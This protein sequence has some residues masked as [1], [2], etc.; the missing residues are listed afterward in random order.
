MRPAGVR[1]SGRAHAAATVLQDLLDALL[2]GLPMLIAGIAAGFVLQVRRS[3]KQSI[4]S[5]AAPAVPAPG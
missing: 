2:I 1:I 3:R 4:R 5:G